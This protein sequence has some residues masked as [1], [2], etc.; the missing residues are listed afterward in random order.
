MGTA[1]FEPEKIKPTCSLPD[2][3]KEFWDRAKEQLSEI[4]VEPHFRELPEREI[5][6]VKVYEVSFNNISGKIYGILCVPD[7]AGKHPA[8][9]EL[10]GAGVWPVYGDVDK[11]KKGVITLTIG[12]HGIPVTMDPSVYSDLREGALKD[13]WYG[14]LENSD[15]YCYKHVFLGCVRAIDFIYSLPEFDGE[16]IAV[17]GGSQGGALSIVTASLDQRID[18][19][20]VF[21]PAFCDHTGFLHGR[22]GGWPFH[23]QKDPHPSAEKVKTSGY[24][25]TV[26]FARFLKVPG[27]Y[28]WGY[29]DGVCTPTSTFS[30]YNVV[31]APKELF[32]VP[33]T[34][35]WTYPEQE[36]KLADWL[37]TKLTK[38]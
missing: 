20:G 18:Y 29:N 33:E 27:F 22:A 30:A 17:S 37:I 13:Y 31:T 7:K 25:D 12:I 4:A 21:Y 15:T 16:N 26:N 14:N 28:S 1:G 11:A 32:F 10:P 9:L 34:G 8:L 2:D 5:A 6:G 23:F 35:H 19:L 38:N 3:F 36:Q 24:Y